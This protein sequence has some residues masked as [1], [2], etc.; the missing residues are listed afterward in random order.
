MALST[1]VI[2]PTF[3]AVLPNIETSVLNLVL[4]SCFVFLTNFWNAVEMSLNLT[5]SAVTWE[6]YLPENRNSSFQ[7]TLLAVSGV[8]LRIIRSKCSF[9]YSTNYISQNLIVSYPRL[10][11]RDVA[12]DAIKR[13]VYIFIFEASF[14]AIILQRYKKGGC[15]SQSLQQ[16]WIPRRPWT[17]SFYPRCHWR[18]PFRTVL[19]RPR[20]IRTVP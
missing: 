3:A 17:R 4:S 14:K 20:L 10:V 8:E 7:Q 12:T 11:R 19:R 16:T 2:A 1:L 6:D 5:F 13:Y 15:A 9:K 18:W